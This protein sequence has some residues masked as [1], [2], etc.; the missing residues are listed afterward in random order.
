MKNVILYEQDTCSKCKILVALLM[1]YSIPFKTVM[2]GN[3]KILSP[4]KLIELS[5]KCKIPLH[6]LI[7]KNETRYSEL[8][9]SNKNLT[10]IQLANIMVNNPELIQ[11][12]ILEMPNDA[13]LARAPYPFID[14]IKKIKTTFI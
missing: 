11:R 5:Q 14:F 7:R 8:N 12:P 4:E 6:N 3:K 9:L 2:V 13:I 10:N 1:E